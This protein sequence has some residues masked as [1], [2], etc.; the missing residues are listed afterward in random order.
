MGIFLFPPESF[1][2]FAARTEVIGNAIRFLMRHDSKHPFAGFM[3]VLPLPG[4]PG[5]GRPFGFRVR[6]R[7]YFLTFFPSRDFASMIGGWFHSS[8]SDFVYASSAPVYSFFFSRIS[9]TRL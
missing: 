4:R 3:T 6:A 1:E 7:D 5:Q 9:P 8:S 2:Y